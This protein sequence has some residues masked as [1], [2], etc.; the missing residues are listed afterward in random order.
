MKISELKQ[1]IKEELTEALG[2]PSDITTASINLYND[3]L[4]KL[5]SDRSKTIGPARKFTLK[6]DYSFSDLEIP[7]ADVVLN[8]EEYDGPIDFLGMNVE[9]ED[10]AQATDKFKFQM[11][12]SVGAPKIDI[13]LAGPSDTIDRQEIIKFIEDSKSEILS[14]LT[15]ELKHIYDDFKK[16]DAS[17]ASGAKYFSTLRIGFGGVKPLNEF[18]Y[19]IYFIH[20]VENLVRPSEIAGRMAATG[21]TKKEFYNFLTNDRVFKV[22]KDIQGFTYDGLKKE[23][24]N[25]IPQIKEV[26]DYN[27]IPYKKT[28]Q[29]VID[30]ILSTTYYSLIDRQ[31]EIVKDLLSSSWTDRLTGFTGDKQKFWDN[32]IKSLKKY[33]GNYDLFFRNEEKYFQKTATEVI[34]KISKLYDLAKNDEIQSESIVNWKLWHELLGAHTKLKNRLDF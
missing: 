9:G 17:L 13:N 27:N 31:T 8:I 28:K 18:V 1:L 26:L 14:S 20:A 5:K 21:V 22:L 33:E 2:V 11:R 25:Y 4:N 16:P 34:K 23:L 12:T 6:G 3:F 24:L 32:Y 19:Y 15:H 30:T 7:T 29:G 10:N